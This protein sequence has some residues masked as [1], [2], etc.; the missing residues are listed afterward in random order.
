MAEGSRLGNLLARCVDDASA[1]TNKRAP[2][3]RKK[4]KRTKDPEANNLS[5]HSA[6]E[7]IPLLRED[8]DNAVLKEHQEGEIE[9]VVAVVERLVADAGSGAFSQQKDWYS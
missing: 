9:E 8:E 3:A 2:H 5:V 7:N 4:R 1:A 6:G